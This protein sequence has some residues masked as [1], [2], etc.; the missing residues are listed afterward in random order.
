MSESEDT[1]HLV[2]CLS[3]SIQLLEDLRSAA[4]TYVSNMRGW[5]DQLGLYFH[6]FGHNSVN[7]LHLH[8]VDMKAIGPTFKKLDYKNCPLNAV[9]KVLQEELQLASSVPCGPESVNRLD[10]SAR[11]ALEILELNVAGEILAISMNLMESW[12]PGS[13]V[14]QKLDMVKQR[15]SQGRIFLDLP[16]MVVKRLLDG[17]RMQRLKG[18]LERGE[19]IRFRCVDEELQIV[20]DSLGIPIVADQEPSVMT[21]VVGVQRCLAAFASH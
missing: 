3:E 12:G 4:V 19:A 16:P 7:S 13:K 6:V 10:A 21:C 20:A 17:L 15:D 1:G 5:S 2:S 9:L 18:R 8:L 11:E 14:L